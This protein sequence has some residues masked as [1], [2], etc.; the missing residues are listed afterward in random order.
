[1]KKT[2]ALCFVALLSAF[3]ARAATIAY[4]TEEVRLNGRLELDTYAGT[5]TAIEL[6]YGYFIQD[7]IEVG[8]FAGYEGDDFVTSFYAGGFG[9][10]NLDTDSELVPFAGA[11]LRLINSEFDL[12]LNDDSAFAPALG[13]Y[14]GAKYFLYENCAISARFLFEGATDDVFADDEDVTDTNFTIDLGLRFFY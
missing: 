5:A 13:V 14:L 3:T 10:F 2:I 8:G 1:M 11:Q 4:N 6:G 12:P 7:Y 9:E